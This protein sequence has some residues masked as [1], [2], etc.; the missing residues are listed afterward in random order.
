[1]ADPRTNTGRTATSTLEPETAADANLDPLSTEGGGKHPVGTGVGAAGGGTLGAVIG[2]AVGGPV[3][4]MIG[5]AVGGITGGLAGQGIAESIDPAEEDAFWRSSYESRPYAKGRAYEDLRPAYKYGW[6]ARCRYGDCGWNAAETELARDW[7][8]A[9][10]DTRLGWD[11]AK[12]A[13]R[14]AWDR[15]DQ[16]FRSARPASPST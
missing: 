12:H 1:M 5:A 10:C 7:D 3:G 14:D 6:E 2:G 13:T 11:E 15:V 16:R 9:K 4:A 8:K